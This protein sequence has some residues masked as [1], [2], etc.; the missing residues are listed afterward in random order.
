MGTPR[1]YEKGPINLGWLL[2]L[3]CASCLVLL[4][5]NWPFV[6]ALIGGTVLTGAFFLLGY[7]LR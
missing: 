5:V 2:V 3:F 6:P 7:F 1:D 4:A